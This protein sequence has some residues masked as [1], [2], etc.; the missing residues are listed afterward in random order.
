[1]VLLSIVS[2]VASRHLFEMLDESNRAVEIILGFWYQIINNTYSDNIYKLEIQQQSEIKNIIELLSE[3]K[4]LTKS[5]IRLLI[6]TLVQKLPVLYKHCRP[7]YTKISF[8]LTF[9]QD[10]TINRAFY[11]LLTAFATYLT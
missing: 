2:N 9:S 3:A 7:L 1:M 10:I 4:L 8:L 6:D 5:N 11:E